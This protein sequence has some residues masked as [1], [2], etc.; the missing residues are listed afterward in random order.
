MIKAYAFGDRFQATKFRRTV[1]NL[2][3]GPNVYWLHKSHLYPTAIWAFEHI[4]ASALILQFLVDYQCDSW[5]ETDNDEA[6][7]LEK[8]L[9]A[10]FLRRVMRGLCELKHGSGESLMR[11][12]CYLEHASEEDKER[13]TKRH[14]VFEEDIEIRSFE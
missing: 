8:G 5:S 1:H 7:M 10:A 12:R 14:M 13:C 9:P 6:I 4:P 11:N 3:V 2:F